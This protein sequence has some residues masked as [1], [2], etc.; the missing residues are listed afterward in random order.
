MRGTEWER[1]EERDLRWWRSDGGILLP[2]FH[3]PLGKIIRRQTGRGD[4][5]FERAECCRLSDGGTLLS[6]VGC[7]LSAGGETIRLSDF[8]LA[9]YLEMYSPLAAGYR[10]QGDF[11]ALFR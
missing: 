7:P 3:F 11:G 6:V 1:F 4:L 5:R 9:W 8:R 10:G 2:A